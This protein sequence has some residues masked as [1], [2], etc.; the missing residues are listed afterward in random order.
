MDPGVAVSSNMRTR[1]LF[2]PLNTSFWTSEII[3]KPARL[4]IIAFPSP[5]TEDVFT[6]QWR[7][8]RNEPLEPPIMDPWAKVWRY[9]LEEVL[10][11]RGKTYYVQR[12]SDPDPSMVEPSQGWRMIK[13]N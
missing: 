2:A 1:C 4:P 5:G 11:A 9:S 13:D 6:Q 12:V 10:W 8:M 7:L 3:H